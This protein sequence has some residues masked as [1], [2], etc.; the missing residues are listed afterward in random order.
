MHIA[1]M[2]IFLINHYGENIDMRFSKI[3]FKVFNRNIF[4]HARKAKYCYKY[5]SRSFFNQ[6][7]Q[8]IILSRIIKCKMRVVFN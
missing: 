4:L 8:F 6:R 7:L 5:F 2:R 3:T 1:F